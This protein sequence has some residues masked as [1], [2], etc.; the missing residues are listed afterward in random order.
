MRNGCEVILEDPRGIVACHTLVR[1][2][3]EMMLTIA[4][5]YNSCPNVLE[6]EIDDIEMFYNGLRSTLKNSTKP[7]AS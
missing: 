3:T 1:V 6:M 5:N 4:M 7:A 2:Y